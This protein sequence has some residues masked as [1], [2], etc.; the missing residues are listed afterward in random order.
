MPLKSLNLRD[1]TLVSDLTPLEGMK[2]ETIWFPPHDQQV[3]NMSSLTTIDYKP[4]AQ[5]CKEHDAKQSGK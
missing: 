4:A 3:R 1:C 2:L 5:F